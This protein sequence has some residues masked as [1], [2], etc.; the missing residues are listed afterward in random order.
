MENLKIRD[1]SDSKKPV[2]NAIQVTSY[3]IIL[4]QF[5]FEIYQENIAGV[6]S[7]SKVNACKKDAKKGVVIGLCVKCMYMCLFHAQS[8]FPFW[9][10]NVWVKNPLCA[11]GYVQV[12]VYVCMY[13]M[14]THVL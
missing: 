2:C 10:I 11:Q 7:S 6:S 3:Y 4:L 5:M 12:S 8:I 13:A 1:G 9:K 14:Y